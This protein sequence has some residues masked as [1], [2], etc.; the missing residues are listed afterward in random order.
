MDREGW[1]GA[2]G[3]TTSCRQVGERRTGSAQSGRASDK[4]GESNK[5]WRDRTHGEMREGGDRREGEARASCSS[6]RRPR[7]G[8]LVRRRARLARCRPVRRVGRPGRARVALLGVRRVGR[9]RQLRSG[10]VLRRVRG[11]LGR[12]DE[13]LVVVLGRIAERGGRCR[14]SRR[15][16]V[17]VRLEVSRLGVRQ[18]DGR[19]RRGGGRRVEGLHGRVR[20]L[21]LRHGRDGGNGE[22]RLRRGRALGRRAVCWAV[23]DGHLLA[24]GP[25]R[26]LLLLALLL[27]RVGPD[28]ELPLDRRALA[29]GDVQT[30]AR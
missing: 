1:E 2:A 26:R 10:V 20:R 24:L 17:A 28:D 4:E 29:A 19:R 5:S 9:R 23:E 11:A 16:G 22:R 30:S 6:L 25:R 7:A 8:V 13:R 27:G 21:R 14:R 12:G 15:R 18:G 3:G